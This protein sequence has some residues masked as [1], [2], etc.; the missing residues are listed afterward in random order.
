MVYDE[1]LCKNH[2]YHY[3][4]LFQQVKLKGPLTSSKC[5]AFDWDHHHQRTSCRIKYNYMLFNVH[6]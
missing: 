6:K 4:H 2:A 1:Y 3:G 5:T